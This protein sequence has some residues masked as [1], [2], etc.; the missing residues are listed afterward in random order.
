MKTFIDASIATGIAE[1]ITLPICT[2]KTNYQNT[3]EI[4]I[5]DTIKNIYERGGI[6]NFYKA[7][8]PSVSS[9]VVSTASKYYM[10][11]YFQEKNVIY[12]NKALNGLIS[13][14]VSSIVTHPIDCIKIH[15]Q[16]GIDYKG[17]FKE[18]GM[19]VLYRGYTKSFGKIC[20]G[21]IT[22]LPIYSYINEEIHNPPVASFISAFLSTI[23]I[24]PVDYMKT[25]HVYGLKIYNGFNIISY[26]KGIGINLCRVVPHFTIIM[27]IID[28]LK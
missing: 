6:R 25:R 17:L 1:I 23:L 19:R 10:Y 4:K 3:G 8:I 27:T 18:K 16:M 2:I 13:G 26:Y 24:H 7:T 11:S 20:M 12:P 9:Q 22:Y 5:G 15:Y 21:S 28:Y 14:V